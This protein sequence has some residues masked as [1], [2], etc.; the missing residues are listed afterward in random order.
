MLFFCVLAIVLWI[1]MLYFF[2]RAIFFDLNELKRMN[3]ILL[4][5]KK[6]RITTSF[7]LIYLKE[8]MH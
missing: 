4:M 1:V 2:L 6:T 5:G 8:W 3:E 7:F